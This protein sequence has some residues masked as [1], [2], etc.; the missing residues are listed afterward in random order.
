LKHN[1]IQI[2][3]FIL[4]LLIAFTGCE[5][6]YDKPFYYPVFGK[7]TFN[8]NEVEVH[9]KWSFKI[10]EDDYAKDKVRAYYRGL[11]IKES[12]GETFRTLAKGYSA[13]KNTVFYCTSQRELSSLYLRKY[14]VLKQLEWENPEQFKVLEDGFAKGKKFAYWGDAEI[15]HDADALSFKS[16]GKGFASDKNH[17]FF[18]KQKIQNSFGKSFHTLSHAYAADNES[19]F[20]KSNK[21]NGA[22]LK[23][24]VIL[25]NDVAKDNKSVYNEEL[26]VEGIHA[27]SFKYF[28]NS[29]FAIDKYYI[30]WNTEL[31]A[32]ADRSTFMV[33]TGSRFAKDKGNYFEMARLIKPDDNM[34]DIAKKEFES[35]SKKE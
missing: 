14:A 4:V 23:T 22:D 30:Y 32:E 20:Y 15:I 24:F 10:L 16:L 34:Y 12:D 13:D 9:H 31:I 33:K 6:G 25:S 7:V 21:I 19:I 28:T 3:S 27:Q 18:E 26:A 1:N 2:V 11:E 17:G 29:N 8:N 35:S 5:K